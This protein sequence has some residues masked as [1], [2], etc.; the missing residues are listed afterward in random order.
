PSS[1]TRKFRPPVPSS[2][3]TSSA[4]LCPADHPPVP[5]SAPTC[6]TLQ[7][8]LPVPRSATY[9]CP[10]VPPTFAH[11]P[12]PPT[13]G[14]PPVQPSSAA[15]QCHHQCRQ[16]VP[17]SDASQCRLSGPHNQCHLSVPPICDTSLV[18]SIS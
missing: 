2:A 11:P 10:A 7:C 17:S 13:C 9:M 15:S 1:A 14:H 6:A 5:S 16:S 3:P 18:L 12:M 8:H 4:H